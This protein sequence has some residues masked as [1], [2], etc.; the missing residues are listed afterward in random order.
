MS[1]VTLTLTPNNPTH[2]EITLTP[3]QIAYKTTTDHGGEK[4]VTRVFD[5]HDTEIGALQWGVGVPDRV[6]LPE[7][8]RA[9]AITEWM[10]K[11]TSPFKQ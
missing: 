9:L 1:D 3:G 10:R 11:S 2:T 6:K 5:A 8:E 7:R 4:T